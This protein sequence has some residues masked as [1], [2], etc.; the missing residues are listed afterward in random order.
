MLLID[1]IAIFVLISFLFDRL[2]LKISA[3]IGIPDNV[4]VDNRAAIAKLVEDLGDQFRPAMRKGW[5]AYIEKTYSA[6]ADE[7]EATIGQLRVN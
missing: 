1:I 4:W 5:L 7:Y 6:D 2:V 3:D